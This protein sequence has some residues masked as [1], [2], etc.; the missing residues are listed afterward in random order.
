MEW[1]F[2]YGYWVARTREV[3]E[4]MGFW[5]WIRILPDLMIVAGSVLLLVDLIYKLYLSKKPQ[6]VEAPAA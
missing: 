4:G 1:A 2:N 3:L 5:L 6:T